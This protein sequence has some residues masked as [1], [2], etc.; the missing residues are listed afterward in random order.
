MIR[1]PARAITGPTAGFLALGLSGLVLLA[2]A[3]RLVGADAY[4]AVAFLWTAVNVFGLGVAAP[5]EQAVTR[6]VAAGRGPGSAGRLALRLAGV[7]VL[8][9]A[10]LAALVAAGR[11]AALHDRLGLLLLTAVGFA[12]WSGL[13]PLRGLVAGRLRMRPYTTALL[14]ESVLRILLVGS[15]FLVQDQAARLLVLAAAVSLPLLVATLALWPSGRAV[16]HQAGG[17]PSAGGAGSEQW[18]PLT[19]VSLSNQ[20]VLNSAPLWLGATGALGAA[21][22]GAFVSAATYF[23]APTLLL[24]GLLAVSLS[25]Q[26]ALWG[27]GRHRELAAAARRYW[28]ATAVFTAGSVGLLALAAPW[29]LPLF[30]GGRPGVPWPTLLSL[31]VS[32]VVAAVAWS[33]AQS[34]LGAH[35]TRDGVVSWSAAAAVATGFFASVAGLGSAALD[36]GLVAGPVCALAIQWRRWRQ[37]RRSWADQG[38]VATATNSL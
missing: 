27:S 2:A 20:I 34:L 13:G 23:R 22:A 16:A 29:L 10:V 7:A 11:I 5:A 3:P 6:A 8:V 9:T 21:F 1:L 35:A 18:G 33:L 19:A 31:G 15:A 37:L 4:S 36:V 32:T 28:L 24:G 26:S 12:S 38:S 30:Y 17:T 14:V 25:R